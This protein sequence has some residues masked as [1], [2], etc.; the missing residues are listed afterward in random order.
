MTCKWL[1]VCQTTSIRKVL[2]HFVCEY[3]EEVPNP[4]QVVKA[5]C[6]IINTFGNA[7]LVAIA[8]CMKEPNG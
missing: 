1:N 3:Y 8:P 7:G 4:V 2:S 5:R 6:D